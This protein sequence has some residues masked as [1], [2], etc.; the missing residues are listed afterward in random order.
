MVLTVLALGGTILGATTIAGLLMLY[1]LRQTSDL[2]SSAKAITAADAG[3]EWA[4]YNLFCKGDTTK[5]CPAPEPGPFV[6][7]ATV[8]VSCYD[9]AGEDVACD[10]DNMRSIRSVGSAGNASRA[11]EAAF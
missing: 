8:V 11:F 5:P 2:A 4:F 1:Q 6:N 10:S 9:G 3:M 7:G